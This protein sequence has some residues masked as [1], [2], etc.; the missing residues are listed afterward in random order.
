MVVSEAEVKQ[1]VANV[2]KAQEAVLAAKVR[3]VCD[4]WNA[5]NAQVVFLCFCLP[6]LK[7]FCFIFQGWN[8]LG[9]V[10][11]E[12]TQQ[13]EW[14]DGT[15]VK[16]A[17]QAAL[18]ARLGAQPQDNKKDK[19]AAPQQQQQ[20]SEKK[21]AVVEKPNTPFVAIHV[22]E[23][24]K[25]IGQ[26]VRLDGWVHEVRV[27]SKMVFIVLR[28]AGSGFIQ[29]VLTGKLAK[30]RA[31]QDLNRETTVHIYGVIA[32]VPEGQTAEGGI[33]VQADYLEVVGVA[34]GDIEQAVNQDSNDDI[35]VRGADYF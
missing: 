1:T 16:N 32:R 3:R 26:R 14:A 15:L 35:K 8:A 11:K 17:V 31:A 19:A 34:M 2:V 24:Q 27:Q 21:E 18:E 12:A 13:L 10:M 7:F 28:D 33:E 5:T 20:Q 4:T 30:T 9:A 25:H 29:C 23:A 22:H 6:F